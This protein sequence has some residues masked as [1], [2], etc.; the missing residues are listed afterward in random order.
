[1][2]LPWKMTRGLRCRLTIKCRKKLQDSMFGCVEGLEV[3]GT[4]IVKVTFICS[5][6]ACVAM[7]ILESY[8]KDLV[9]SFCF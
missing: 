9:G 5:P 4:V 3:H 1:M 8:Y 7:D 6:V 2:R